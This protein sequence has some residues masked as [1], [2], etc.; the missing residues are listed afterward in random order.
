MRAH[1]SFGLQPYSYMQPYSAILMV[2]HSLQ[3]SEI[4][5]GIKIQKDHCFE[6]VLE[7]H[8]SPNHPPTKSAEPTV[9]A[10]GR[11][12]LQRSRPRSTG[13]SF[14]RRRPSYTHSPH[15][16]QTCTTSPA[17][18]RRY[19]STANHSHES[20]TRIIIR[21]LHSKRKYNA[22][23]HRGL[24]NIRI[25]QKQFPSDNVRSSQ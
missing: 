4:K 10:C 23:W 18:L 11:K 20:Q 24:Q 1:T 21:K 17:R 15:R 6:S 12:L 13:S 8:W 25:R 3:N 7:Q 19:R 22:L 14:P 16:R 9:W 2:P 5:P